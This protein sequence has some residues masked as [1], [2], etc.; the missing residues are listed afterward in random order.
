MIQLFKQIQANS[1]S[2]AVPASYAGR[3][4]YTVSELRYVSP[5]PM[6][7]IRGC[8][9]SLAVRNDTTG[10]LD[11]HF[12]KRSDFVTWITFE[13]PVN[14]PA[15]NFTF[16]GSVENTIQRII[17]P[18]LKGYEYPFGDRANNRIKEIGVQYNWD[19]LKDVPWINV[20]NLVTWQITICLDITIDSL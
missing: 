20:G 13:N 4:Q 19:I 5:Q 7:R 18:D 2:F 17:D 11:F 12:L 9:F 16:S 15:F 3:R 14:D 10:I 6:F 1:A 8:S